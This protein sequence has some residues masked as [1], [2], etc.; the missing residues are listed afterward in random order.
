MNSQSE[1]HLKKGISVLENFNLSNSEL[2]AVW[3][4]KF[5][6]SEVVDELTASLT[7]TQIYQGHNL[8]TQHQ[9]L[10]FVLNFI[11]SLVVDLYNRS[12]EYTKEKLPQENEDFLNFLE[13]KRILSLKLLKIDKLFQHPKN[14]SHTKVSE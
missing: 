7:Y 2:D 12:S 9:N 13:K 6:F 3:S 4:F 10:S 8:P 11:Q 14:V 5:M 1:E